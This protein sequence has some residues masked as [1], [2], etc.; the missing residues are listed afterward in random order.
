M[1]ATSTNG[2]YK[3]DQRGWTEWRYVS[4]AGKVIGSIK[5]SGLY[6]DEYAS[7]LNGDPGTNLG[8]FVGMES[9]KRAVENAHTNS[10]PQEVKR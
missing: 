2:D 1:S 10:F 4:P 3:W 8:N 6:A 5:K 9:A 7:Y